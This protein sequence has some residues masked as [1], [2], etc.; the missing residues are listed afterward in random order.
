MVVS[1]KDATVGTAV[2]INPEFVVSVRPDPAGP[3]EVSMVK[4]H[5]GE[6]VKVRGI[7]TE[8]ARKLL[9]EAA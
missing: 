2:Y 3:E 5:D 1:F 8:V 9:L 7:H 4:L 6:T